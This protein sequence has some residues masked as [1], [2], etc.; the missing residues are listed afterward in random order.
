M[1]QT[2]QVPPDFVH[3][4]NSSEPW[5]SRL[6]VRAAFE[7]RGVSFDKSTRLTLQGSKLGVETRDRGD[8]MAISATVEVVKK[9]HPLQIRVE[10]QTFEIPS[11]SSWDGPGDGI[12]AGEDLA[13]LRRTRGV[14]E[15][16][17]PFDLRSNKPSFGYVPGG[18][19]SVQFGFLGLGIQGKAVF[20]QRT[21]DG[22]PVVAEGQ[23][24]NGGTRIATRVRPDGSRVVV[25]V[26]PTIV[27]ATGRPVTKTR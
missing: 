13:K 11:D 9:G 27:D 18:K 3:R 19:L 1:Q 20:D 6:P 23:T 16:V 10:T 21:P 5:D 26:T 8:E 12:V 25:A 17:Q 22:Q 15:V 4:I 24:P 7:K 14:E 2:Y